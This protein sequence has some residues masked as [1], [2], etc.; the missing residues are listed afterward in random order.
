MLDKYCRA[1]RTMDA[2]HLPH[3][4]QL[5]GI[6]CLALDSTCS[7][8]RRPRVW[9]QMIGSAVGAGFITASAPLGYATSSEGREPEPLAHRIGSA[10]RS[11]T[12]PHADPK[13]HSRRVVRVASLGL[14][15]PLQAV[16]LAK[17]E[18]PYYGSAAL[19]PTRMGGRGGLNRVR[20]FSVNGCHT[21]KRRCPFLLLR[22]HETDEPATT[23]A[24][25]CRFR[26]RTS[27]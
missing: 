10:A 5:T 7:A 2:T 25:R 11:S 23:T 15:P 9:V 13:S 14:H 27:P 21:C 8:F 22:G 20:R 17:V 3:A 16:G 1:R 19:R 4:A 26:H 18:T 6:V 12:Q 24:L